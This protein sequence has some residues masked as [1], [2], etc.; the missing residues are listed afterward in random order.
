MVEKNPHCIFLFDK[1]IIL[2]LVTILSLTAL[3]GNYAHG[4]ENTREVAMKSF[5]NASR[6]PCEV[7][8]GHE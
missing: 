6:K 8:A 2:F 5:K 3:S 4:T 7:T 1:N